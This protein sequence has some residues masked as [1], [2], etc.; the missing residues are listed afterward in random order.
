MLPEKWVNF[1]LWCFWVH[2]GSAFKRIEVHAHSLRNH[3][4][5]LMSTLMFKALFPSILSDVWLPFVKV[6]MHKDIVVVGRD[7]VLKID[8]FI[9]FV[10]IDPEEHLKPAFT[11]PTAVLFVEIYLTAIKCFNR[12]FLSHY[13]TLI[14]TDSS[15]GAFDC[16]SHHIGA[17]IRIDELVSR[18]LRMVSQGLCNKESET[19]NLPFIPFEVQSMDNV[20]LSQLQCHT[21]CV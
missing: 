13:W 17:G 6:E 7:V 14:V 21:L 10:E 1:Y 11:N 19:V 20:V 9:D 4:V 3:S 16:A 5:Q 18:E 12:C 8:V 15:C 2:E